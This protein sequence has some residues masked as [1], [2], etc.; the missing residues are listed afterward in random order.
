[1]PPL[2]L[3][4]G[5]SRAGGEGKAIGYLKTNLIVPIAVHASDGSRMCATWVEADVKYIKVMKKEGTYS[6]LSGLHFS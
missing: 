4:W 3:V 2:P 6:R 5:R 1:M